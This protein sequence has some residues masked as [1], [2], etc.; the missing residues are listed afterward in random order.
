MLEKTGVAATPG[1][2]FDPERGH[3]YLR[4][5]FAGSSA[6]IAEAARR[7]VAWRR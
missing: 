7:L 6:D 3:R 5:S 2:D 1:M 4:F